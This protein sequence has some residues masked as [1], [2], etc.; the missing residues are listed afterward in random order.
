LNFL[1]FHWLV[2]KKFVNHD[3]NEIMNNVCKIAATLLVKQFV[4]VSKSKQSF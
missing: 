3:F 1:L 4:L 2:I